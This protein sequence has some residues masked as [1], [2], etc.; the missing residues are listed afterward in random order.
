MINEQLINPQSIVIVGGSNDVR[1]PGGKV[2]K[3]II[4]NGFDGDIYVANPKEDMVQ[5]IKCYRDMSLLPET[6]LAI[7]AIAAKHCLPAVELLAGTK[8]TRAFIILSAGF[9]EESEEGARLEKKITDIVNSSGAC[10]IGPNCIGMMN[11]NHASVFTTPVPKLQPQGVDFISGSG[12]VAVY[13]MEAGFERGLTFSSVWSVGNSPQTGVE[14]VIKY[15]DENFDPEKSSRIKLLYMESIK[16]PGMLLKH[17]SSLI[18]KGCRIAAIKSGS[19]E[20]GSRAATSHT[21]ALAGSDTA[22]DALFRKAGIVR[23]YGKLEL[24]N[25]A[26]VFMGR[27]LRGKRIAIVTHAGGS[28][29]MLTDILSKGGLDVPPLEGPASKELLEKLYPGSSTGNPIDFLATGNAEQLGH[30]LDYCENQFDNIDGIAVIFGSPGLAPV[31]DVY[32]LL[33]DRIKTCRKPIY[34]V[35]PSVIN[36]SDEI[37]AFTGKGGFCFTDEVELGHALVRFVNTPAPAPETVTL[38]GMDHARIRAAIDKSDEGY[39]SPASI[40][41]ILD[42]AGIP[43]VPEAVLTSSKEAVEKAELFGYPVVMKV[44]GP[45]HKSDVGGVVLNIENSEHV[46]IEFE[47]MMK[48]PDTTAVLMQ[49]MLSGKELFAGVKAEMPFGHMV[50]CG[51]GGIFV[52][53]FRDVKEGLIPLGREEAISM[54]GGLKGFG[55]LKGVR[56]ERGV[57]LEMYADIL[58]RLSAMA[59]IAPEIVEMDINPLLGSPNKVIAVD[60]RVRIKK[61][62]EIIYL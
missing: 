60:A 48:I 31:Y 11:S 13:T 19:S 34:P 6:D 39:M 2:L 56:G 37:D 52:E 17:A 62:K 12:A 3:N 38:P 18:R 55:I 14:E 36:A 51:L 61:S 28:A 16:K 20:A 57:D 25:T 33:L 44:I 54:I 30:I 42:G 10:L 7:L 43:R 41:E 50:L 9:S 45:V 26:G 46:V 32:D 35:L 23:C 24:I 47:R 29:V 40:H 22:V 4:D 8:N 58:V 1:K 21:G 15:L 27:K 59:H 53:V 49:P 5:G